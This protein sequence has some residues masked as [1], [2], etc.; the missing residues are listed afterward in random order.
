MGGEHGELVVLDV[1]GSGPE[2]RA[3]V[4]LVPGFTGSKEDFLAVLVPLASR[5]HRVVA[6][7]QR[8][9]HESPRA[10][11]AA[12]YD[13]DALGRDVLALVT[14]LGGGVHALGHSFGG[15]VV[16]DAAIADP[17]GLRS[18]TL[19][20]SGPGGITLRAEETRLLVAA[21]RE[22]DHATVWQ[23]MRERDRQLGMAPEP[24]MVEAFLEERWMGTDPA[25][26]R[27]IAE[28]LLEEN[29]RTA[30]LAAT[31]LPLLVAHGADDDAWSP[32]E[33][34]DMAARLGARYAVIPDSGHSPAVDN[35]E[36][37]VAILAGFFAD[38]EG[39]PTAWS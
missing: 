23:A 3:P 19:L 1:P 22:Y 21:M 36:G 39:A 35:V 5:G 13:V 27:R 8:G 31:G 16:R 38:V 25:N 10:Q 14:E 37:T 9:Q 7:D 30:D 6:I 34:A 17:S 11:D 33:Q 32:A 28:H 4:L 15:L 2:Q 26:V 18:L 29:D 24:A 20:C 12:H